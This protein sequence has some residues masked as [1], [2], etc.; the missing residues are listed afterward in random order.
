MVGVWVVVGRGFHLKVVEDLGCNALTHTHTHTQHTHRHTYTHKPNLKEYS[1]VYNPR[2][3][4][5]E[6]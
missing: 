5:I 6:I 3:R 4:F 1:D 2:L